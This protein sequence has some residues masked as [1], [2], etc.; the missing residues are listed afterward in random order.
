MRYIFWIVLLMFC[1][2]NAFAFDLKKLGES[3]KD[4][5]GALKE[6]EKGIN[7]NQGTNSIQNNSNNSQSYD[8]TENGV[9]GKIINGICVI[10]YTASNGKRYQSK[11]NIVNGTASDCEYQRVKYV[12]ITV[13]DLEN[14]IAEQKRRLKLKKEKWIKTSQTKRE[15]REKQKK[16]A[17]EIK[18]KNSSWKKETRTIV[19]LKKI[20]ILEGHG[21]LH[22]IKQKRSKGIV[23][24]VIWHFNV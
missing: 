3:Q 24:K 11:L 7:Q 1:F 17:E 16:I 10:S 5:G 22:S 23:W 6:L 15:Q 19:V 14:R 9:N 4:L 8:K 12:K 13:P 2:K 18:E 20:K 21:E